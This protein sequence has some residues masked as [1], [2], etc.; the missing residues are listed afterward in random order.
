[1]NWLALFDP[2]VSVRLCLVLVHSLWQVALLAAVAWLVGRWWRGGRSSG[3]TGSTSR[4]W[5]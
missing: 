2:A 3:A 4:P 5:C 1:M